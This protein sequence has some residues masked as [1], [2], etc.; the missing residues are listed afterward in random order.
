M[1]MLETEKK[2]RRFRTS[3]GIYD[4]EA[5]EAHHLS[6]DRPTIQGVSSLP[7]L[8]KHNHRAEKQENSGVP[9]QSSNQQQVQTLVQ[10][11]NVEQEQQ[12]QLKQLKLQQQEQ[13]HQRQQQSRSRHLQSAHLLH[14]SAQ[15]DAPPAPIPPQQ[16]SQQQQQQQEPT[17]TPTPDASDSSESSTL[18]CPSVC[19]ETAPDMCGMAKRVCNVPEIIAVPSSYLGCLSDVCL[20]EDPQFVDLAISDATITQR[21]ATAA[22]DLH[23]SS[24]ASDLQDQLAARIPTPASCPEYSTGTEIW[25]LEPFTTSVPSWSLSDIQNICCPSPQE[26]PSICSTFEGLCASI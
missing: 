11:E 4:S 2:V 5:T 8:S 10:S 20:K 21:L 18:D 25:N 26:A 3:G 24:S 16:Q 19:I 6:T 22:T 15:A 1:M 9:E 12:E 14:L 23:T 13:E 7:V 17:S